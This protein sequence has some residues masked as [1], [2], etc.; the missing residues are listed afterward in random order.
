MS[1]KMTRREAGEIWMVD[2][3]SPTGPEQSGQRPAVILQD[4]TLNDILTTVIV[5]PLTTNLKR[6]L[7]PATLRLGAGEGRLPQESIVLGYQVQVRGKARCLQKLGE[8]TPERLSEVQDTILNA[9]GL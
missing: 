7:M 9:L 2:F 8:L 5:A 3:G 4:D 1:R 6:V